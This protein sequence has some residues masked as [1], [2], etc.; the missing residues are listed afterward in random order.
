MT[1]IIISVEEVL[2]KSATDDIWAIRGKAI[3]AYASL[4]QSLAL[5]LATLAETKVEIAQIIF[6]RIAS[7]DARNK[8]L[9]RLFKIKFSDQ[10]PEF[11][12]SFFKQLRPIDL[13]RN[14]IVHWN[15][16]NHI[17][18]DDS[19]HSQSSVLLVPPT[20]LSQDG[21][22]PSKDADRL[23]EFSQ[24]C[25]FY[26]RLIGMFTMVTGPH[27]CR[28]TNSAR[29]PWLDIFAQPIVYPPPSTHPLSPISPEPDSP[30][31]SSGA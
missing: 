6:F 9:E 27:G 16:V 31:Q 22:N 7:A 20:Y 10:Y 2:R 28:M 29:Q 26:S 24:K 30:P 8:I 18:T 12:N 21:L 15:I 1:E 17:T 25:D 11:R 3:Q 13:E 5:L 14:E 4:E 19:G 23:L